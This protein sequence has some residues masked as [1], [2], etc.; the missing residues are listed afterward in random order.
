MLK[1]LNWYI[2]KNFLVTFIASIGVLT[3]GMTGARLVKVFEYI[4][5]GVDS[6]AAFKFLLYVLP[7]ALS[8]TIPWAAL[9]S[10]M[11]VDRKSVV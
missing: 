7:V 9:V 6:T 11:L 3:F 10:I 2:A 4:S 5:E 1:T 8:Y